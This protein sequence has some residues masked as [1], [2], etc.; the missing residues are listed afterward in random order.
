MGMTVPPGPVRRDPP[1]GASRTSTAWAS[2]HIPQPTASDCASERIG[3]RAAAEAPGP[4]PGLPHR[5]PL[6]EP[7]RSGD[8]VGQQNP[9]P[10]PPP[11]A[12]ARARSAQ[13]PGTRQSSSTGLVI[14]GGTN[15]YP[16][17]AVERQP[18]LWR[19]VEPDPLEVVVLRGAVTALGG[20]PKSSPGGG[21]ER[22][23]PGRGCVCPGRVETPQQ[24]PTSRGTDDQPVDSHHPSAQTPRRWPARSTHGVLPTSP[25]DGC[26]EPNVRRNLCA[27][28]RNVRTLRP[29]AAHAGGRADQGRF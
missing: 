29:G 11:A 13:P 27:T 19:E 3:N 4:E 21:A 17:P 18:V 22:T 28:H 14:A 24:P 7:D 8:G 23:P 12:A 9:N 25:F 2:W 6:R 5:P 15:S 16:L 26:G 1:A 10:P 20:L